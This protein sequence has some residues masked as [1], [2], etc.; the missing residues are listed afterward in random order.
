MKFAIALLVAV[1]GSSMN[2]MGDGL[3]SDTICGCVVPSGYTLVTNNC[4]LFSSYP[5]CITASCTIRKGNMTIAQ[6]CTWFGQSTE[7]TG[8][9]G[10]Y[11]PQNW[12]FTEANAT[13][14]PD[15]LN[16]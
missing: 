9:T 2:A 16:E 3:K 6:S 14:V 11:F 1:A 10:E 5:S 8:E 7:E 4:Y 13:T 12:E 15:Q